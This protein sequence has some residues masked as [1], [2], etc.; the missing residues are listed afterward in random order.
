MYTGK[1]K[2]DLLLWQ[3][4]KTLIRCWFYTVCLDIKNLWVS[5]FTYNEPSHVYCIKY[6]GRVHQSVEIIWNHKMLTIVNPFM[7]NGISHCYGL[8]KSI[9]IL[10]LL[11][12]ILHF[13]QILKR[14]FY[15]QTVENPIRPS[16][17]QRLI[18]FCTVCLCPT[19]R[20]LG[21]YR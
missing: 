1:R 15:K 2:Q 18:W 11:G 16:I 17:L 9:P 10:G 4:V 20:R 6:D 5:F 8:D 7:P 3:T 13:I 14:N 21:L 12:G 19:K